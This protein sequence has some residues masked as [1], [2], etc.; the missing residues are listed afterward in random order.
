[1]T[2][3]GKRPLKRPRR[4]GTSDRKE[5]PETDRAASP[6]GKLPRAYLE[7][8]FAKLAEE[9]A[10]LRREVLASSSLWQV[11]HQ[12]ALTGLWN[13]RYM[14]ERLAEEISRSK[15]ESRY[16]FSVVVVD[17]DN[18]K[19]INDHI[20]H[21]AGDAALRWVAQF[22]REG[23][24]LHDIC[25]RLGG[26]EFL[27]VLPACGEKDA[28][29]FIERLNRRWRAAAERDASSVSISIGSASYPT[30]GSTLPE[31]LAVADDAMYTQKRRRNPARP[32]ASP[33]SGRRGGGDGAGGS[34]VPANDDGPDGP[35]RSIPPGRRVGLG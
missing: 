26:D 21:A 19:Y 33:Q 4:S 27:L 23:L 32:A 14:D 2:M 20:G 35:A 13:R 8:A 9:N 15:R 3:K 24:R 22:L 31:L 30:H 29:E 28:R 25:A 11:A 1:M 5:K 10:R 12:D 18:L 6:L 34:G 17:V 16:R 7:R